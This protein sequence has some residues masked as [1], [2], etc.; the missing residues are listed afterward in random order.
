MNNE[1]RSQLINEFHSLTQRQQEIVIDEILSVL[2]EAM[3]DSKGMIVRRTK[4]RTPHRYNKAA[5]IVIKGG[6][7]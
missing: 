2:N 1:R 3:T 7:P 5:L 4:G 6:R